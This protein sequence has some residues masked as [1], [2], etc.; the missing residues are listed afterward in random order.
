MII[1]IDADK[2]F[3]QNSAHIY[4]KKTLQKIGAEGTYL[5][6]IKATY[7]KITANITLS[8]EKLK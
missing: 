1:S 2:S 7:D 5:N 8:V 4:D 6:I 3:G